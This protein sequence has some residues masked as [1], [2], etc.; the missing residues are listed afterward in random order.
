MKVEI[1]DSKR[2]KENV[3]LVFLLYIQKHRLKY[4]KW[5]KYR[6]TDCPF[7]VQSSGKHPEDQGAVYEREKIQC[8]LL[9]H[10]VKWIGF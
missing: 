7:V 10:V 3:F 6:N 8:N 1:W 2:I 5:Q 9:R 4:L